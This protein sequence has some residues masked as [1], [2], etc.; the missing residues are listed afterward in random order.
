MQAGTSVV[1][2]QLQLQQQRRHTRQAEEYMKYMQQEHR[3]AGSDHY[4]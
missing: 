4:A 3:S 2:V 1:E